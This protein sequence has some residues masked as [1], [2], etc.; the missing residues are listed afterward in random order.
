MKHIIFITAIFLASFT[1]ASE[2]AKVSYFK[3]SHSLYK[4]VCI[5]GIE[6]TI[7][8]LTSKLF[9]EKF[10]NPP[11]KCEKIAPVVSLGVSIGGDVQAAMEIAE[12][13]TRN[14]LNT[15]MWDRPIF[16]QNNFLKQHCLSSCALIF[17]SGKERYFPDISE[18]NILVIH[19]PEFLQKRSDTVKAEMELDQLKYRFIEVFNAKLIDP[20]FTIR[21]FETK[22]EDIYY[23][24][25]RELLLWRVITSFEKPRS[26]TQL[27]TD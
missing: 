20:N 21:M 2:Q 9:K 4:S 17:A 27:I 12:I 18:N 22:F 26:F 10:E 24:T 5:M 23:P 15:M 7:T 6:G 25:I 1:N 3:I 11:K 13:I 8:P 16:S 19:K 14:E